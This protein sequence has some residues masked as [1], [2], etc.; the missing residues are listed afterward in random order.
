MK[1]NHLLHK[2]R[3]QVLCLAL[4]LILGGFSNGQ[5]GGAWTPGGPAVTACSTTSP[6]S[7]NYSFS[8]ISLAGGQTAD[9]Y[10]VRYSYNGSTYVEIPASAV[11]VGDLS[12]SQMIYQVN[13][14]VN[15]Y[16]DGVSVS[17]G[18]FN[19]GISYNTLGKQ[20]NQAEGRYGLIAVT[21][22]GPVWRMAAGEIPAFYERGQAPTVTI[23]G[24]SP[25]G[26]RV[27]AMP[28]CTDNQI[29]LKHTGNCGNNVM[30][31]AIIEHDPLTGS[32]IG[33]AVNGF[34]N[35]AQLSSLIGSGFGMNIT[36]FMGAGMVAGKD[37][38]VSLT[39]SGYLG[40]WKTTHTHVQLKPGVY[41]LRMRDSYAGTDDGVEPWS[42]TSIDLYRSPDIWNRRSNSSFPGTT[43][44]DP[45][46]VS[47]AGNTNK[48]VVKVE[49]IGCAASPEDVPL[50]LFWTR[51]R[52]GELW[53]EHWVVNIV[54]GFPNR[55][56]VL[57]PF[58]G[59]YEHAGSEITIS[60]PT[61]SN[62]YSASINRHLLPSIAP[63]ATFTISGVDWFPPDPRHFDATNGQ[64]YG[65]TQRPIICL[66]ARIDESASWNFFSDLITHDDGTSKQ[67]ISGYVR[68]NNNVVARNTT[69]YDD[70]AFRV[71]NYGGPSFNYGFS[72]IM[73]D[74]DED[75]DRTATICLDAVSQN[76][77]AFDD[78]G[79]VVIAMTNDLLALWD[80]SGY[81]SDNLTEVETGLFQLDDG[82]HGC[83]SN[84]VIPTGTNE[85]LG[86]RFEYD[87][88]SFPDDEEQ[89]FYELTTTYD[90][91]YGTENGSSVVIEVGLPTSHPND[92]GLGSG[93]LDKRDQEETELIEAMVNVYPNPAQTELWIDFTE[94]ALTPD[95]TV[96][97]FNSSGQL[98]LSLQ[99]TDLH[100]GIDVNEWPA[101]VY[102]IQGRSNGKAWMTQKVNIIH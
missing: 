39:Y 20:F 91:D 23:N 101:G 12:A 6:V 51:A 83:I 88:T 10:L 25:E 68:N 92:G 59:N 54:P 60:S 80:D 84:V 58:S 17:N 100:T 94:N 13:L 61:M 75:Q 53:Y 4:G 3:W 33:T 27:I 5:A 102:V 22:P 7:R 62:P 21:S 96:K 18:S 56:K 35:A 46:H 47:I 1:R 57:S 63:G 14:V 30:H 76:N 50:R 43:H 85:V 24:K 98:I 11:K 44:Q 55:N 16:I 69:L 82:A 89:F 38:I 41:D 66:L 77:V 99:P 45:D 52:A 97:I 90:D 36:N 78:Y 74:N 67:H 15:F 34:L 29:W 86:V 2:P 49:N 19:T 93:G 42:R 65:Q 79:S 37:Y 87:G 73:V 71:D 31:L 70:A 72:T 26:G 32:N 40:V 95:A 28:A 9:I 64:M 48:L 8:G 81:D